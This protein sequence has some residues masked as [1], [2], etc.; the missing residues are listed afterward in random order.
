MTRRVHPLASLN[1]YQ[2]NWTIKV[3]VTSKGSIRSYKNA[4]GEGNVFNIEFTDEDVRKKT[5]FAQHFLFFIYC[6]VF[7][8]SNV[9]MNAG[10]SNTS[11]NVQ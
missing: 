2:G 1:P 9:H 11:N 7:L 10:Y 6:E 3:R 5:K 4:R 8:G